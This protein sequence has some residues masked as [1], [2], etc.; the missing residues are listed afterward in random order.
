MSRSDQMHVRQ[1]TLRVG[2]VEYGIWESA[3]AAVMSGD[4]IEFERGEL[5]RAS[6]YVDTYFGLRMVVYAD[7]LDVTEEF[8]SGNVGI[9]AEFEYF[10]LATNQV[11]GSTQV[12]NR[13][14]ETVN[15]GFEEYEG[16]IL[17]ATDV[18]VEIERGDV[19]LENW[20][21]L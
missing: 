15:F 12:E 9:V 20:M 2:E 19:D 5:L 11:Y 3:V 14:P 7:R 6:C 4:V 1:V 8:G 21:G 17:H 13:V 10:E 16:D 18:W